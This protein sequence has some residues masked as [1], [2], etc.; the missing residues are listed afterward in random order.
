MPCAKGPHPRNSRPPGLLGRAFASDFE[1]ASSEPESQ[2]ATSSDDDRPLVL[3]K[4][5]A[6][7]LRELLPRRGHH[8]DTDASD[9]D[10][11]DSPAAGRD[12]ESPLSL[13]RRRRLENEAPAPV[14][15]RRLI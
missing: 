1:E 10:V 13:I 4:A 5:I 3:A 12:V 9:S 2:H 6:T 14:T 15:G 7:P 11:S 8:L